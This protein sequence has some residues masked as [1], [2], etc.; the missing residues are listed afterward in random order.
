[1]SA[2]GTFA[3]TVD[4]FLHHQMSLFKMCDA[5][6]RFHIAEARLL[7]HVRFRN[8]SCAE[9]SAAATA[10]RE[11]VESALAIAGVFQ[12]AFV[13]YGYLPYCSNLIWVAVAVTSVWLIKVSV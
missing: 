7:H 9:S 13:P 11:C 3:L 10:Y 4:N 5:Y 12:E 6:F 2:Q 1:M 8:E